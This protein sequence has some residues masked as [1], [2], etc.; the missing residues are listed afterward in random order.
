LA[1]Q[2]G[3]RVALDRGGRIDLDQGPHPFGV[4]LVQADEDDLA[5]LHAAVAHR[6]A[7]PEPGDRVGEEDVVPGE[8]GIELE[9]GQPDDEPEQPDHQE[10]DEATDQNIIGTGFHGCV[11]LPLHLYEDCPL[12][13]KTARPRGPPK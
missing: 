10:Q 3:H 12:E 4:L 9:L 8:L 2:A 7:G 5:H 6:A 1:L 13:S 11:A